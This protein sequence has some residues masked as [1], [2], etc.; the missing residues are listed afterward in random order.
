MFYHSHVPTPPLAEFIEWFWY[1]EDVPA[2]DRARILPSG[3]VELVLNLR[4]D[5]V[6]LEGPV[7][8][9][10]SGAVVSGAYGEFLVIDPMQHASMI[11]V[12]F[13][14]GGAAPFL[15]TLGDLTDTHTD[16]ETVW[17][18]SAVQLREQLCAANT[19]AERF[20]ILEQML[21]IR[22]ARSPGRHRA[23]LT[24]LAAFEQPEARVR[25]VAGMVGLSQRRFIQVFAAEVGLTP[26]LYGRVRRFQRAR[27]MVRPGTSPNWARIAV[28]C[29]YFDQAHLI[30]DFRA[31]T[32]YSPVEFLRHQSERVLPLHILQTA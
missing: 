29:G 25:D 5:E 12:H 8:R 11:G 19:P 27:A 3:T 31:F 4:D 2:Y 24:A 7:R 13:K 23:V 17:G 20:A 1:C 22:L 14:P 28:E 30:H 26:K 10:L 16:L 18:R 15:G 32:G 6:R 9:R 21:M